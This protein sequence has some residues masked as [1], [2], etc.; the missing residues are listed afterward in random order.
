MQ[1]LTNCGIRFAF[2]FET[3]ALRLKVTLIPF[4]LAKRMTLPALVSRPRGGRRGHFA[5]DIAG[6]A[7]NGLSLTFGCAFTTN[8][9]RQKRSS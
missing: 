7:A 8:P 3:R 2:I 4:A 9:V 6:S 1:S 5:A